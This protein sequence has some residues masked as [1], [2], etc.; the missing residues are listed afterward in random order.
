MF[1][2]ARESGSPAGTGQNA[3]WG[4]KGFGVSFCGIDSQIDPSKRPQGQN[5]ELHRNPGAQDPPSYLSATVPAC[6]ETRATGGPQACAC[7]RTPPNSGKRRDETPG[8]Q[9]T[10]RKGKEAHSSLAWKRRE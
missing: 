10:E 5:T 4:R 7:T 6:Q 1:S 9:A 3:S 2:H 8:S